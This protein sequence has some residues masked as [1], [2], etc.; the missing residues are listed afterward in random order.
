MELC[1]TRDRRYVTSGCKY[2]HSAAIRSAKTS[3]ADS[4]VTQLT[5]LGSLSIARIWAGFYME[6]R[7]FT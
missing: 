4:A 2:D 7:E 3:E 6:G 5:C 1:L